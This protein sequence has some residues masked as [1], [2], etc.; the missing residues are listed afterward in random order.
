MNNTQNG[1]ISWM[2]G[3]PVAA[4]LIMVLCLLGG[5]LFLSQMKQEVFPEFDADQVQINVAY[6]GAS[7]E[8][9][10]Q[11]VILAIEEAVAQIDGIK[12]I[13]SSANESIGTVTVEALVGTDLKKLAQDIQGEVDRI[14]TFP[15]DIEKPQVSILTNKRR[16]VSVAVYGNTSE[17][18]LHELSEQLRDQL[19]S[20]P[21]ITQADLSGVRPLEISI[22]ISQENLRRYQL[23]LDEVAR[24]LQNASV[25]LPSGSVKALNGEILIRMKERRDFGQQFAGLPVITT[26]EGGEVLLGQI[27]R[28]HDHYADTDYRATYNGQAAMMVNVYRVGNETPIQISD[29]VYQHLDQIRPTLPAGIAADVIYDRS[30]V[31]QQRVD[32]LLRNSALGLI[33]VLIFLAL[34][35]E[36]RL[37]FWVMMGIPI[38]F[39]GAFLVL[40]SL[41]VSLNM[42]SLFAFIVAL[43]IVVDDA[44]IVGENVYHYRL[45]GMPPLQAAIR[46]ARE[47]AMP[48]SFSILTNI[49]TFM[50]LY[51][52]PGMMGKIFQVIPVVVV[53]V[54][55]IS[56]LESLFVLP[57]HL[58]RIK[59][60][61][62][63]GAGLWLHQKQQSFSLAFAH[64]VKYRFGAFLDV[65][66]HHRYF[67][68]VIAFSILLLTLSYAMSGRMGMEMFPK[69][70]SDFAVASLTLPYG[71]S[72]EK[73]NRVVERLLKNAR[74][75]AAE[76][77]RGDE[78]IKGVFAETGQGGSHRA[79]IRVYM[80]DPDIRKNIMS[81]GEF[82]ERWRELTGDISGVESLRFH[83][84]FGGPGS[85]PSITIEASHRNMAVLERVSEQVANALREYSSVKDVDD[86]FSQGKQQLDF[87]L[88]PE[89]RNLGFTAQDVARQVRAAFYGSEVVRQQ[90]GRNEI[91]VMVRLPE[92][93][94]LSERD[95]NEL[96]LM[97]KQGY[98]VPLRD[99]VNIERGH[100]YTEISR[101][102]GRRVIQITA[103][104]MPQS[105]AGEVL[106]D[107][108]ENLLSKLE[109]ENPG[110]QFNFGGKQAEMSE[111]LGSLKVSFVI[112]ML[113]VYA[114][115]AIPFQSYIQPAI[116]MVAIPF[117]IIGAIYGHLIM[118]YDLSITSLLGVVALSG[119]VVNDSLVLINYANQLR[120]EGGKTVHE[121][122]KTAAI[123]RFRAI[124]LTTLTTIGGLSPM[125]LETSIQA[126]ILIPMAVSL[127]FGVLFA[128]MIT[129]ILV[130]SLY[131]IMDDCKGYWNK[132]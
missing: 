60:K 95:I 42:I 50:P 119:I 71:S 18:S 56:L 108:S 128:T 77:P 94:R 37:A 102:N 82:T 45:E 66:L 72:A 89:G 96:M 100:A 118:G 28:I 2:A 62:R 78:L 115:L 36:I 35:L 48:I 113:V 125:I 44:I 87:S 29:R 4:N 26:A 65:A 34:F 116:V 63:H 22:E 86:G 132:K 84:D 9:V 14:R 19:L 67:T 5:Y 104:A 51:F 1:P 8:E 130:P 110:L 75:V 52:V 98:A 30:V 13:N 31:Y 21:G 58:A 73:T 76:L 111:S 38:S 79:I 97:T 10:E 69:T 53:T 129:L 74:D 7:P 106:S 17:H 23:T 120:R 124:V 15:L 61:K 122:V 57:A 46:G 114:M 55:I 64:W 88:R 54:F 81:T 68:V 25:D 47:M 127:G 103:N 91:K 41:G 131:L 123:Q 3:H 85:G 105:K 39:L 40:P 83:S 117:G 49:A 92:T 11:G 59:D 121:V 109:S 20:D 112:A 27:A 33:L 80:S 126:R 32:L 24:R 16:V 101:Q 12:R 90:R 6:P 43:G 93:E 99:V 107:L 70:E